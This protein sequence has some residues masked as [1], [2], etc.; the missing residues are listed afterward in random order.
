MNDHA[1]FF[2]FYPQNR[3]EGYGFIGFESEASM[4]NAINNCSGLVFDGIA[5]TCAQTSTNKK[6]PML[7]AQQQFMQAQARLANAAIGMTNNPVSMNRPN[8]PHAQF[9]TERRRN[10]PPNMMPMHYPPTPYQGSSPAQGHIVTPRLGNGSAAPGAFNSSNM[11]SPRLDWDG[12]SLSAT[13]RPQSIDYGH[14]VMPSDRLSS[15]AN[16]LA[17][18]GD[19]YMG[20]PSSSI[21]SSNSVRNTPLSYA[22]NHNSNA[23]MNNVDLSSGSLMQHQ[24]STSSSGP[25]LMGN[26]GMELNH[27]GKSANNRF[28]E[29]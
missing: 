5:I 16:S 14:G 22:M 4:I 17:S 15:G 29:T 10:S 18:S 21:A 7:A 23:W 24:T 1:F 26:N 3:Q 6:G 13:S 27:A 8:I 19:F 12:S 28:F 20:S 11:V 9:S 2:S 25:F